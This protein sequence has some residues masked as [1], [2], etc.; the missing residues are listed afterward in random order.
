MYK[1]EKMFK[2]PPSV[3]VSVSYLQAVFSSAVVDPTLVIPTQFLD[4]SNAS[5]LTFHFSLLPLI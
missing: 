1:K 4:T 5:I 2:I 3:Y